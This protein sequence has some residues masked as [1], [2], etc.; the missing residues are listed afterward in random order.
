MLTVQCPT[1]IK[2]LKFFFLQVG[3][4]HALLTMKP[5]LGIS[6]N[7]SMFSALIQAMLVHFKLKSAI[8]TFHHRI[9]ISALENTE[10]ELFKFS[11]P[12]LER[13]LVPS[14]HFLEK[15]VYCWVL[16]VRFG[17]RYLKINN[18]YPKN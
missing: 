11:L 5:S 17:D 16:I 14:F 18:S 4:G 1:K 7:I 12:M 6:Y 13:K 10:T 2:A 8:A 3:S 9:I 15:P